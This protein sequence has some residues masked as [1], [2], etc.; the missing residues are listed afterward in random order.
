VCKESNP[1]KHKRNRT[2]GVIAD[3]LTELIERMKES[4]ERL[5]VLI[6]GHVRDADK[7]LEELKKLDQDLSDT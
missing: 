6:E 2:M 5:Q 4:D 1:P 7:A 3:Q